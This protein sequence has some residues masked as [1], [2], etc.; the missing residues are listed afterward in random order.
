MLVAI[1]E[2][3]GARILAEDAQKKNQP[4]VCPSCKGPVVLKQGMKVIHHY[5]HARSTTC[6][7]GTG[8]SR[9]HMRAKLAIYK[10]LK[11]HER[12]MRCEVEWPF[13]G[14]IP[15]VMARISGPGGSSVVAFEIQRT[16]L[17]VQDLIERT[18]RYQRNKVSVLWMGIHRDEL[19]DHE[20]NILH[21]ERWMHAACFGRAYYW[22]EGATVRAYHFQPATSWVEATDFGGG[23]E[24]TLKTRKLPLEAPR[25]LHLVEDFQPRQQSGFVGGDVVVPR[26]QVWRDLL[27]KWW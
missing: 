10:A 15:D 27:Q 8:E 12:V 9:E 25:P 26:F 11:T 13:Q 14:S 4:F 20:T 22:T 17:T 6:H 5:A 23:Y 21:W 18:R 19:D 3:D 24:R 1:R 16:A 7:F 2:S